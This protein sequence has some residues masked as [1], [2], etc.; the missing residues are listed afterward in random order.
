MEARGTANFLGQQKKQFCNR[1]ICAPLVSTT[2][3]HYPTNNRTDSIDTINGIPPI[4]AQ[5]D[6]INKEV[7]VITS[8]P[9][10]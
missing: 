6:V 8:L 2:M 3:T 7:V 10:Q 4:I 1:S 9:I 5:N